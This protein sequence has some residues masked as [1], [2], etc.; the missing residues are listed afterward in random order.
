MIGI[1]FNQAI[2]TNWQILHNDG[3]GVCEKIDLGAS[4][5][6]SSLN[7][8]YTVFIGAP[9]NGSSVWVRVVEEVSGAVEEH[10]LTTQIPAATTFLAARLYMNNGGTAAA[11]AYDCSGVYLETDF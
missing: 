9:A 3:A 10:E 8:V 6:V 5:P 7:N 2:D 1:G 11:C 4:F